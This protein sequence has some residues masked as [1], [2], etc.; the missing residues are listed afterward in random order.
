MRSLIALFLMLTFCLPARA[1][2]FV[3]TYTFV[4]HTPLL[5]AQLNTNNEQVATAL[6]SGGNG[7]LPIGNSTNTYTTG[8]PTS[9]GGTIT[10][11]SGSGSLNFDLAGAAIKQTTVS[12]TAANIKGMYASPVTILAAPGT[13]HYN[14][15]TKVI[16]NFTAGGTA[17]TS[18]GDVYLQYA[19]GTVPITT[20]ADAP[21]FTSTSSASVLT[22]I[23]AAGVASNNAITITN[24]TQA[25]ATGNG[26]AAVTIWYYTL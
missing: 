9:T 19:T 6:T 14:V 17:F 26:T 25:F 1:Q 10:I 3:F 8:T 20:A 13:G 4:P 24:Q 15:V 18:G 16:I 21:S 11:T 5:A 12:L 7:Y 22:A 2:G 23:D